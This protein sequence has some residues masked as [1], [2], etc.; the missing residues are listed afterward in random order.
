VPIAGQLLTA[1]IIAAVLIV[2]LLSGMVAVVAVL[3]LYV[4]LSRE[5]QRAEGR[6]RRETEAA[7][8]TYRRTQ[9]PMPADVWVFVVLAVV[10]GTLTAVVGLLVF[11]A[12]W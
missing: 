7:A 11:L 9:E 2:L 5:Q 3:A 1:V 8:T 10:I 6:E 4:R 12:L